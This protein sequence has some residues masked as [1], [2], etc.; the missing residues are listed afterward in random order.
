M[1]AVRSG[2]PLQHDP[3][4]IG[5]AG[6]ASEAEQLMLPDSLFSYVLEVAQGIPEYHGQIDALVA[7]EIL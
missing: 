3:T 6:H 1:K 2:R 5:V 7:K 4:K